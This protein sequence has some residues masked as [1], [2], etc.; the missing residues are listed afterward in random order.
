M[1]EI[2]IRAF[3][4]VIRTWSCLCIVALT[5]VKKCSPWK[6]KK[7]KQKDASH[8]KIIKNFHLRDTRETL[9]RGENEKRKI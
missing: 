3:L 4:I 2:F 6:W 9:E 1:L 5:N 8:L 7:K